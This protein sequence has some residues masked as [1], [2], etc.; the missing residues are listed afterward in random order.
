MDPFLSAP[1]VSSSALVALDGSDEILALETLG[2][3]VGVPEGLDDGNSDG[4]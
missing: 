3:N 4:F 2:C 1:V